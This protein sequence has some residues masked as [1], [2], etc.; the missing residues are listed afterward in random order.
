MVEEIFTKY[1]MWPSELPLFPLLDS[2]NESPS[3]VIQSV[4]AQNKSKIVRKSATRG[5]TTIKLSFNFSY[6]QLDIFK[7]FFEET[8][9]WGAGVFRFVHPITKSIVDVSFSPE[10]NPPYTVVFNGSD[11]FYKVD[12]TL[13]IWG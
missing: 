3:S 12:F 11:K 5:F 10:Q 8:L 13:M 6:Q 7:R 1:P 9:N 2:Y 4:T